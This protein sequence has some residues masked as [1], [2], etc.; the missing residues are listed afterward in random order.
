MD[1]MEELRQNAAA[2]D[3]KQIDLQSIHF[4]QGREIAKAYVDMMKSY[5]RLNVQS[6]RY[7]QAEGKMIVKGFCRLEEAHF[8]KPLLKRNRKQSFWTAQWTETVTLHKRES[9]L[10]DAFTT[11]FTEFC[12]HAHIRIGELS[13]LVRDKNGKLNQ[14]PFPVTVTLP[15]Y[16]EAI[17]FPYIIEF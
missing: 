2:Y 11:S 15:E 10:Y 4:Q 5:A 6:G 12:R 8:D 14:Q 7:E 3:E 13:A 1:F 16:L 9:A 17:G